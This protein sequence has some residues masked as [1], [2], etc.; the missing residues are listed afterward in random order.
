GGDSLAAA[1]LVL[2]A[3]ERFGV[4]PSLTSFVAEPT[5][6]AMARAIESRKSAPTDEA[7]ALVPLRREGTR[8]PLFVVH[9]TSF[10]VDHY[11]DFV[12]HLRTDVPVYGIQED[13]FRTPLYLPAD[14]SALASHYV[15]VMRHH[16]PVGPYHLA[17]ASS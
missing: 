11:R 10:S 9:G 1:E 14:L 5:V 12:R 6:A 8:N 3:S 15:D 7:R 4:E 17:G 16:W 2:R 13:L